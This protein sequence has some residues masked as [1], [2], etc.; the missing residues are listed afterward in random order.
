MAIEREERMDTL[1]A[2]LLELAS[3]YEAAA[4]AL[5]GHADVELHTGIARGYKE[6]AADI[7]GIVADY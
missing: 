3:A 6:A 1:K 7:R 4:E 5:A 2:E